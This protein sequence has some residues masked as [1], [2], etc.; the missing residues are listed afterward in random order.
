MLALGDNTIVPSFSCSKIK[1]LTVLGKT[2]RRCWYEKCAQVAQGISLQHFPQYAA[3]Q[4][5]SQVYQFVHTFQ[6][7]HQLPAQQI[8][9]SCYS[10]TSTQA[11]IQ[12]Q[13]QT[14]KD[15]E[16]HNEV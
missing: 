4:H 2:G 7:L 10:A 16:N 1:S 5:Y 13:F 8:N 12:Q 9:T 15:R 11:I 6:P 14:F 3:L